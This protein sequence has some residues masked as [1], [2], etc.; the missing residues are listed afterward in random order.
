LHNLRG[1]QDILTEENIHPSL[2][3]LLARFAVARQKS[4]GALAR[5]TQDMERKHVD[6]QFLWD[7]PSEKGAAHRDKSGFAGM[8][9]A[10][11]DQ[12]C[13][14]WQPTGPQDVAPEGSKMFSAAKMAELQTAREAKRALEVFKACVRD[15]VDFENPAASRI[16]KYVM[17]GL[18]QRNRG[19][20]NVPHDSRCTRCFSPRHEHDACIVPDAHMPTVIRAGVH[21]RG[22]QKCRLCG[23]WGHH[24]EDCRMCSTCRRWGHLEEDCGSDF[25]SLRYML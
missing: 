1:A 12:C 18:G 9:R 11:R 20:G 7:S 4:P 6:H 3:T 10:K 13:E 14:R 8:T 15:A 23:L 2:V 25:V 19:L 24:A 17:E 21:W 16:N 5:Q 22:G